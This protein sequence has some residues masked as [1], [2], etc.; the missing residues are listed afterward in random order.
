M[1]LNARLVREMKQG[2]SEGHHFQKKKKPSIKVL[3]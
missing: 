2:L 1:P 3:T